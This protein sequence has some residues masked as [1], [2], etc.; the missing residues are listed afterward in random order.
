MTHY[1]SG[2]N[3]QSLTA[4]AAAKE[5]IYPEIFKGAESIDLAHQSGNMYD[6]R[7]KIDVK[8]RVKWPG[9]KFETVY[10]IQERW[11]AIEYERYAD[12]TITAYN[13]MTNTPVEYYEGIMQYFLYGYYDAEKSK[14]G[15]VVLIDFARL[16][17]LNNRGILKQSGANNNK[18]LKNQD[19]VCFS[20]KDLN[21]HDCILWSNKVM[22]NGENDMIVDY[23]KRLWFLSKK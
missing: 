14:F 16:R 17:Y 21:L 12:I 18:G 15:H 1:D 23:W 2:K 11:R 6:L 7:D 22:V 10:T 4:H 20:F 13:T 9:H 3:E 8:A 5:K 19:F